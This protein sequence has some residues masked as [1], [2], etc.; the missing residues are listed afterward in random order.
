MNAE[1]PGNAGHV[2]FT[3]K[4]WSGP[5]NRGLV[6]ALVVFCSF[7]ILFPFKD[8]PPSQSVFIVG[9]G[10]MAAVLV[11][12]WI[13]YRGRWEL[14]GEI[15]FLGVILIQFLFAPVLLRWIT[16]D[17]S[18]YLVVS[19][20]VTWERFE[21]REGHTGGMLIVL[22]FIAVYLFVTSF[23][24]RIQFDRCEDGMIRTTFSRGSISLVFGLAVVLWIIRL[25]LLK[26]GSYYH[27]D[28]SDFPNEDWR[29]SIMAQIDATLGGLV[30]AF[31]VAR[32]LLTSQWLHLPTLL[33]LAIDLTWN[34]AS[35]TRAKTLMVFICLIVTYVVARRR[36]P[37]KLLAPALLSGV[38]LVGF[39]DY[40]RYAVRGTGSA[41]ELSVG[42]VIEALDRASERAE[43]SGMERTFVVGLSRLSD[44]DSIAA[45]YH[46][47]PDVENHL[48]GE[49]YWNLWLV[50]VPRFFWTEKPSVNLPLNHWFFMREGGSSPITIMG[51]GYFNFGWFGVALAAVFA[52]LALGWSEK[53]L[54][55]FR[56]QGIFLPVYVSYLLAVSLLHTACAAVLLG[57]VCKLCLLMWAA[58]ILSQLFDGVPRRAEPALENVPHVCP[59]VRSI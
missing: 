56:S 3:P 32:L 48:H 33:Y 51:E 24:R 27:L 16:H 26:T 53:F 47:V 49:T 37:I 29:Y 23:F 54:M 39:M 50:F 58:H 6:G 5:L 43:F 35:G 1:T 4:P 11:G 28:R 21:V 36:I 57:V 44:L 14:N 38:L 10:A 8:L 2:T 9:P 18:E 59:N 20:D 34:F 15:V 30:L 41:S 7:G 19:Q 40:Y 52:A 22:G 13:K 31:L 46:W 12:L 45:I 25:I 17:Y 42:R 55:R